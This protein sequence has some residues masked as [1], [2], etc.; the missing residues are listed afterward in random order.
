MTERIEFDVPDNKYEL[1][2][3]SSTIELIK[4]SIGNKDYRYIP[5]NVRKDF[6][7]ILIKQLFRLGKLSTPLFELRVPMETAYISKYGRKFGRRRFIEHYESIHQNYDVLK[8]EAFN[9]IEKLDI[10]KK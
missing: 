9:I 1:I 10:N 4:D 8:E 2:G 7:N 6:T 5:K 3:I